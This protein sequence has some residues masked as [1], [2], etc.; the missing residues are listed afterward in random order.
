MSK[1][2]G[3]MFD[4]VDLEDSWVLGWYLD[5]DLKQLIFNLEVSLWKGHKNYSKP[6]PGEWTCY[7]RGSL[8]F[9]KV[10]K[11]DGLLL[12]ET[13]KYSIDLDGSIDYGNIEGFRYSSNGEYKFGGDF[14]EVSITCS[15]VRLEIA[16]V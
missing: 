5:S 10:T 13:V 8:I 15:G 2:K 1:L 11:I 4:G 12:I 6:L 14:G 16:D 7:K 9:D 3:I